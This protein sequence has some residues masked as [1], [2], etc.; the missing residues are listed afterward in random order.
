MDEPSSTKTHTRLDLNREIDLELVRLAQGPPGDMANG[1]RKELIQRHEPTAR[2]E[3]A[4]ATDCSTDEALRAAHHGLQQAIHAF[5]P[6]R[7]GDFAVYATARVRAA[8]RNVSQRRQ[9]CTSTPGM[10]HGRFMQVR[11]AMAELA[12]EQDRPARLGE[13][14]DRLG[15]ST[16]DVLEAMAIRSADRVRTT[17]LAA[18]IEDGAER[19]PDVIEGIGQLDER[20]R[21]VLHRLECGG[22]SRRDVATELGISTFDVLDLE[23]R[24]R[25]HLRHLITAD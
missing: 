5:D 20:T 23:Q 3:A 2:S 21:M 18:G 15:Y 25:S 7:G 22:R 1:A 19:S 13:V 17:Q 9:A 12:A 4:R 6:D 16:G 14:A 10:R 11:V 8:V 24:G